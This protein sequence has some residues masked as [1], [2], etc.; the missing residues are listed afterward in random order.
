MSAKINVVNQA[1]ILVGANTITSLEDD[2]QEAKVMKKLYY[3]TRDALLESYEWSIAI[4]Q[5][6]PA[7]LSEDVEPPWS[8]AYPLPSDIIR[9]LRVDRG[10]YTRGLSR[11]QIDHVVYDRVIYT[12]YQIGFCT[13]LRSM[14]EEGDFSALFDDMFSLKLAMKAC[15]ALSLSNTI[16]Q[17]LAGM[18]QIAQKQA[19]SRDGQ[20]GTTRRLRSTWM[21]EARR[22]RYGTRG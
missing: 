22:T 9:L 19:K 12:N 20:Q 3:L 11:D 5:W 17:N 10:S 6:T 7:P 16:L 2:S 1:L 4:R 18:F 13:G 14:E 21:E 15:V 8:Y